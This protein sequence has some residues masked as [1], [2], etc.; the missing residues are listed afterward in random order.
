MCEP[1]FVHVLIPV[2]RGLLCSLVDHE[3]KYKWTSFSTENA[4]TV[5]VSKQSGECCN[6]LSILLPFSSSNPH[7]FITKPQQ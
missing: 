5:S 7:T 3:T 6:R 2:F 4:F 1:A